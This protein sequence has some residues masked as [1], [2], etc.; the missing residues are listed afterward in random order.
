[1]PEL[2]HNSAKVLDEATKKQAATGKRKPTMR[3]LLAIKNVVENGSSK[4]EA[5]R[6]AGYSEAMATVPGKVFDS[7][8]VIPIMDSVVQA[9]IEERDAVLKLMKKKRGKAKYRDLTDSV[10]KLTKNI[11]LLNGGP[12]ETVALVAYI[13]NL[14][15]LRKDVSNPKS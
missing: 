6:K 9:M 2:T 15:K 12:T 7:P 14:E 5:I 3:Q 1:M 4:A 11:Q 13:E 8:T 10:D